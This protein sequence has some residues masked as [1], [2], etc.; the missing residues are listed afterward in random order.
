MIKRDMIKPFYS[1][2]INFTNPQVFDQ[3]KKTMKYFDFE[4]H[5][6]RSLPFDSHQSSKLNN[7]DELNLFYKHPKENTESLTYKFLEDKF[8]KYGTIGSCK[9][10]MN[11]DGSHKGF[12]YV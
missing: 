7:K 11:T 10:A 5:Q 1:A 8:S 2:V 9:I 4:G 3:A 12:A 6:C